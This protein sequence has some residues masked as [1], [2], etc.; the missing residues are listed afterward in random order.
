MGKS[1]A[2]LGNTGSD[3]PVTGS[4][5][6]TRLGAVSIRGPE[7]GVES[8]PRATTLGAVGRK[9]AE[10]EIRAGC[11]IVPGYRLV[12]KVGDGPSAEVWRADG[13]GAFPAAMKV[14]RVG[15]LAEAFAITGES[16][17]PSWMRRIRH[18]HLRPIFGAWQAGGRIILA[19]EWA[20]ESLLGHLD[21]VRAGS[22][23]VG[24]DVL[25]PFFEQA[26]KGLDAL[27]EAGP[28]HGRRPHDGLTLENLLLV[29]GCLKVADFGAR[30]L[31]ASRGRSVSATPHLAPEARDGQPGRWSDQFALASLYCEARGEARA[32]EH[33]PP[34]EGT[35]SLIPERERAVIARALA[36]PPEARFPDCQ[37]FVD[38]LR[39]AAEPGAEVASPPPR[40]SL[41]RPVSS[42]LGLCAA[43][44]LALLWASPSRSTLPLATK[45]SASRVKARSLAY[46]PTIAT[47]TSRAAVSPPM[48][49]LEPLPPP[50]PSSPLA[51]RLVASIPTV[52]SLI[53]KPGITPALLPTLVQS[54]VRPVPTGPL[55]AAP[56]PGVPTPVVLRPKANDPLRNS[57]G[58]VELELV[59]GVRWI[60]APRM[61]LKPPPPT[62]V[63]VADAQPPDAPAPAAV[64]PRTA[65]IVVLM[66]NASS[67]LIVKGEVGRGNPDEW[68]GPTRVIHTPPL[69]KKS[70]Y[71]VGAFWAGRTRQALT[72]SCPITVVPGETYEVNLRDEKPS[73]KTVN[74]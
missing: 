14:F 21:R 47:V 69:S 29:G 38:A 16:P 23:H 74:R 56:E 5:A 52:P 9:P 36:M 35:P 7:A 31:V 72:R 41:P 19:M 11:E 43:A 51:P 25:L 34:G 42:I 26:A 22:G 33:S 64:A 10:V 71:T 2:L 70:Q 39:R 18:A 68:Y 57:A 8:T 17:C 13:P 48:S 59:S 60:V 53:S 65:T 40:R 73:W 27:A 45:P 3:Q 6:A 58:R 54:D 44:A 20:E 55:V 28:E 46:K 50:I 63:S 1:S 32:G 61:S 37:S 67:D 12:E 30:E 4:V 62:P 24:P 66:P 49:L 15:E